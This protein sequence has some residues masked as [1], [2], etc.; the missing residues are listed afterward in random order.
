MLIVILFYCAR[1]VFSG[2]MISLNLTSNRLEFEYSSK[3]NTIVFS[4]AVK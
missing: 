3:V 2:Q 4:A 1:K